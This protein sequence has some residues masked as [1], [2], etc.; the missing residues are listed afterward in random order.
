MEMR[1]ARIELLIAIS[2]IIFLVIII[3]TIIIYYNCRLKGII[4]WA[5]LGG[6]LI[7][8]MVLLSCFIYNYWIPVK[9]ALLEEE[10]SEYNNYIL[11]REVHYTGTGW[12]KVGDERGYFKEEEIIDI[13][14]LDNPLPIS[15]MGQYTNIFLC[16]VEYE[17][18]CE[19]N[20]LKERFDTYTILEWYPIY[21]VVRDSLIPTLLLPKNFMAR[22]D[23]PFY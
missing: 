2:I 11:V 6:S 20:G 4:K 5:I 15:K 10:F 3:A 17:G 12:T 1:E 22:R 16:V 9:Y 19:D 23:I 7:L 18:K 21:P 13:R 14:I 8:I